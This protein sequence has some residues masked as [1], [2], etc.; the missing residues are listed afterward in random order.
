MK[1][2]SKMNQNLMWSP[3]SWMVNFNQVKSHS[4]VQ[5]VT[6][7]FPRRDHSMYIIEFIPGKNHSFVKFVER[8]FLKISLDH[9]LM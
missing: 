9:T 5:F 2:H 3:Q 6:R 1:S 4:C 8:I 7:N